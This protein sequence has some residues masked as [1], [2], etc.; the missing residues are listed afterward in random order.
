MPDNA[1][2]RFVHLMHAVRELPGMPRIDPIEERMLHALIEMW[3]EDSAPSVLQA[4]QLDFGVSPTTAHRRLKTLRTKGLIELRPQPGD[5]RSKLVVPT[6]LAMDYFNRL[7][8]CVGEA[9][10]SGARRRA[11]T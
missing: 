9:T 1:F 4:M 8:D 3:R 2:F 11:S 6:A 10:R 5:S 7:S